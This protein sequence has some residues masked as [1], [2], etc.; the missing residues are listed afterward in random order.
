M[1]QFKIISAQQATI[2]KTSKQL[3]G[4]YHLYPPEGIVV[5]LSGSF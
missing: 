5:I 3:T 2:I 4:P 1:D